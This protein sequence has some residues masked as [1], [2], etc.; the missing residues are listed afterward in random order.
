MIEFGSVWKHRDH[1]ILNTA[2][3]ENRTSS[4][5]APVTRSQV[6]SNTATE[7]A[8]ICDL[9]AVD[10]CTKVGDADADVYD[11]RLD[12]MR[13]LHRH[14]VHFGDNDTRPRTRLIGM[15]TTACGLLAYIAVTVAAC[16]STVIIVSVMLDAQC[17]RA[18]TS[19]PELPVEWDA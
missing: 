8:S 9:K 15:M 12:D 7:R 11:D 1:S 19:V 5:M 3:H 14:E 18:C 6:S 4:R 16:A 17:A 13:V 2:H 10:T